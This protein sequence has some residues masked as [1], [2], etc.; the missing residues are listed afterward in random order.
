MVDLRDFEIY[1]YNAIMIAHSVL[2]MLSFV[3]LPVRE[4]VMLEILMGLSLSM[5]FVF[6]LKISA[7]ELLCFLVASGMLDG[8]LLFI[9]AP[10]LYVFVRAKINYIELFDDVYLTTSDGS[11]Y[12]KIL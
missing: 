2:A 1:S 6:I 7:L 8:R 4:S 9:M 10:F 5:M 12:K 3:G 11:L